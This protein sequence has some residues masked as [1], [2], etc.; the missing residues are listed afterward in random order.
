MRGAYRLPEIEY[1]RAVAVVAVILHHLDL[2]AGGFI[3][4]DIFF[5]ISGFVISQA[6]YESDR[7]SIASCLKQFYYRRIIRIIPPLLIVTVASVVFG[8]LLFF[9]D[10][11]T[12]LQ[13]SV[14][15]QSAFL[16]NVYFV[17][18]IRDYFRGIPST[19]LTLHTWS[20]GGEE[21]FYLLFPVCFVLLLRAAGEHLRRTVA[22]A[23]LI[24]AIAATWRCSTMPS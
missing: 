15:H 16:Q 14:L 20:L 12:R 13:R 7:S 11:L 18:S 19:Q 22:A 9:D 1:M 24:S 3:G 4:V 2:I 8:W 21:Q 23:M 10:D 17:E 5:V 6:L